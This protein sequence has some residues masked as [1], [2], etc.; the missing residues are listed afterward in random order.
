MSADPSRRDLLRLGAYAGLGLGAAPLLS[1]QPSIA[2][3]A[4]RAD[5]CILIWLDG[6]ASHVDTFDPKPEAPAEY[7][8]EFDSIASSLDGVRICEHF[9]RLSKRMHHFALIRSLTSPE[10]N[11]D[12]GSHHYQTGWRPSPSLVYPSMGSVLAR[13]R[14]VGEG[15][16]P[17]Y[18]TLRRSPQFGGAG[19]MSRKFDPYV[20]EVGAARRAGVGSLDADRL[21]RRRALRDQL[22]AAQG[23]AAGNDLDSFYDQAFDLLTSPQAL[24]AFDLSREPERARYSGAPLGDVC[25]TARRLVEAGSKFVTVFDTGWDMHEDIFTRLTFGYPGPLFQLDIALSA[26]IDDLSERGMLDRTLVM[27]MG[28][29]G[30]TPKINA[31]AGRDHW[32]KSNF[33]L[34]AGGG[35]R[36]GQVIGAT[37]SRG[38]LPIE[39]PVTP[40]ELVATVYERLGMLPTAVYETEGGRRVQVLPDGV[41]PIG[42]LL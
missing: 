38:E 14:G 18:I 29:M 34:L 4:A 35:I 13:Q 22:Q 24:E 15:G 6:G 7:R 39:R 10:G 2:S 40:A 8:G 19:F 28:E 12:R 42:E 26:L 30:R 23:A 5:A 31:K 21:A 20:T 16:V 25:L 37:D 27:V 17:S 33:C 41:Q 11:H 1:A 36:A 3:A 9:E 32:P